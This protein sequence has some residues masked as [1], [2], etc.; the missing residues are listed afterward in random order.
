[1]F[2][3]FV[4]AAWTAAGLAWWLVA[5]FLVRTEQR[6]KPVPL[7]AES[8]RSLSIFKPLP[9]L[10]ERG[11]EP[12]AAGLESFI[13]Q[14]DAE[15]EVLLGVRDPDREIVTAF[16]EAMRRK[17]PQSQVRIIL[18]PRTDS[19]ANPKIAGQM[20]LAPHASGEL[21]LWSDADIL[22]PPGFLHSIR[23]EFAR[24]NAAMLTFPY[25]VR[26]LPAAPA[27]LE[28]LFV[29][30]DFYPG[31]LLLRR[32]GAVDFGLGSGMLF[33]RE[34]F[35]KRVDWTDLGACLGDDFQLGQCLQP[36]R[37]GTATLETAANSLTWQDAFQHDLRW[38]KTIRWNRPG[39]SFARILILPVLGWLIA[40]ATHPLDIFL[41]A[42]LVGMIQADVMAAAAICHRV[43]CRLKMR[44]LVTLEGWSV[45]RLVVWVL[46]WLPGPVTWSGR[47]WP[48]PLLRLLKSNEVVQ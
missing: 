31:V 42:G 15:S 27:L 21:W 23:D 36:V 44:D 29:N 24:A 13:A 37:I 7:V 46:C 34:D 47:A 32:L 20:L 1:M 6:K 19:V 16:A 4:L 22:A 25:V 12:L 45:W 8:M 30:P 43:G 40:V 48:G 17:Y 3:E 14:L 18:R 5:W 2:G 11:M 39:G 33:A 35:L 10:G 26:E 41:W 9:P 28:A 38:T